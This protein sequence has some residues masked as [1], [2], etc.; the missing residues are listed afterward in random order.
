MYVSMLQA[1]FLMIYLYLTEPIA[2]YT[3]FSDNLIYIIEM[4]LHKIFHII[5]HYR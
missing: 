3:F 1:I 2:F 5:F 4:N